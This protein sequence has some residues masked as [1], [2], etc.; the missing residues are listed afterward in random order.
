MFSNS[1]LFLSNPITCIAMQ[2]KKT[3]V[4]ALPRYAQL[5]APLSPAA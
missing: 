4:G 3:G 2:V 1:E 5:F